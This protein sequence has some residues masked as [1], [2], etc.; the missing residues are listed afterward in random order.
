M[1][2]P[3]TSQLL[4]MD[5]IST[6]YDSDAGSGAEEEE[7]PHQEIEKDA[8]PPIDVEES[9]SVL[10]RLKEKFPLNSAPPVPVRVSF[11]CSLIGILNLYLSF[12][13]V[14]KSRQSTASWS[15]HEGSDVQPHSGP[16]VC[17]RGTS[18]SKIVLV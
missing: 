10:S 5:A 7:K 14:G 1:T 9:S 13:S 17:P 2:S 18:L 6:A 16:A 15:G 11:R 4:K 12:Y 8:I 3:L